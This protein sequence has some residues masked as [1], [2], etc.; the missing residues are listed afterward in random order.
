MRRSL[1]RLSSLDYFIQT[2]NC[3]GSEENLFSCP[4]TLMNPGQSCGVE[5]GVVCR[6]MQ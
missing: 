2:A 5:A 4:Y 6:G 3:T 1:Y